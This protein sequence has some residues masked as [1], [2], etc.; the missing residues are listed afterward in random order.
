MI[1]LDSLQQ[2]PSYRRKGPKNNGLVRNSSE[3][4]STNE[5]Q[6]QRLTKDLKNT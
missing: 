3:I 4:I 2:R 6:I 5:Y 1:S